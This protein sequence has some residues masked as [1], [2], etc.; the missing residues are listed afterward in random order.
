MR[1]TSTTTPAQPG[2]QRYDWGDTVTLIA[3]V[4]PAAVPARCSHSRLALAV[5][6]STGIRSLEEA[7]APTRLFFRRG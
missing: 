2:G 5:R 6:A 4:N 3:A 7:A 1:C